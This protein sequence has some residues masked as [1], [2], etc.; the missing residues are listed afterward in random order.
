MDNSN[1]LIELSIRFDDSGT[2]TQST[3]IRGIS[4]PT[5]H[6]WEGAAF[7]DPARNTIL[8]SDEDRPALS[9]FRLA[10]GA[11]VRDITSPSIYAQRRANF[12]LE[13][14]SSRERSDQY[15]IGNEEALAVDGPLSA[16][17]AGTDVRLS[18]LNISPPGSSSL[19]RQIV[20][21][22]EPMHGAVINGARSG[23]SDLVAL[24]DGRLLALERSFAFAT[25]LFLT[26]VYEVNHAAATD[27]RSQT[28]GLVPNTF[29]RCAKTLL[30]SGGNNNLE[31]LCLGPRLAGPTSTRWAILGIIDDGDPISTNQIVS[32]QLDGLAVRRRELSVAP[33][34]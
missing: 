2:I 27:V 24:P 5:S 20:Y 29:T 19:L 15:W 14:L 17:T 34:H 33:A 21:R 16:P 10:D 31:G 12:G 4:L 7:T 3:V 13:S 30:Y 11:L 6:D 9:E 22:T 28:S 23:L 32:F 25:P 1:K 8:L 18:L 26:R